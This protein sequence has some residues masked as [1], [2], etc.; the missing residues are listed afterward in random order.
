MA[1]S[2]EPWV[3]A[4][5]SNSDKVLF[6]PAVDQL[7]TP[8]IYS[9]NPRQISHLS[10]RNS[11]YLCI[12]K[13]DGYTPVSTNRMSIPGLKAAMPGVSLAIRKSGI[14]ETQIISIVLPTCNREAAEELAKNHE[15][16]MLNRWR[17]KIRF[18]ETKPITSY[19][20]I[21]K[22]A[23][24]LS[25]KPIVTDMES[26][27]DKMTTPNLHYSE[28]KIQAEDVA[29]LCQCTE[30]GSQVRTVVAKA[31]ARALVVDRLGERKEIGKILHKNRKFH[32]EVMKAMVF[33]W[34][35]QDA[36]IDVKFYARLT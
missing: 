20:V 33:W 2:N 1:A 34:E 30:E 11:A 12:Q 6:V 17:E 26:R 4:S 31:I 19:S 5:D 21:A 9:M 32:D 23:T 3:P 7:L 16:V 22:L 29:A 27:I 15:R 25:I 36:G 14:P 18:I 35:R 28:L 24:D 13:D 10:S 8:D